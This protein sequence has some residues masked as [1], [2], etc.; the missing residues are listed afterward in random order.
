MSESTKELSSVDL[1][2]DLAIS[3]YE[4]TER[5]WDAINSR[6]QR[7]LTLLLP[8]VLAVP[9]ASKILDLNIDTVILIAAEGFVFVS[10]V[11]CL[12]GCSHGTQRHIDSSIIYEDYLELKP[13]KFKE[14]MIKFAGENFEQNVKIIN[15]KWRFYVIS[16]ISFCLGVLLLVL[17]AVG[18]P[19]ILSCSPGLSTC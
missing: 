4:V 11:L 13:L 8:L 18:L 9:A 12:V 6:L 17:W 19:E 16:I 1:A 14:Y 7:L 2:Y 3:Y 10:I 5:R 15:R